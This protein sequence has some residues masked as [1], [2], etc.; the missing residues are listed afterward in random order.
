[1]TYMQVNPAMVWLRASKFLLLALILIQLLATQLAAQRSKSPWQTLSGDAP[2]IIARGGFSGLLPDSSLDAYSFVSMTSV[3]DAVLW[4]D[5]QL[6]K[7]GVGICFPDVKMM[8]ASNIQVAYPDRKNSYLLNGVPTQDWFT[9]DFTFKDL[10]TVFLMRGI[11]SRS[12]AFDNNQY[13]ISTVQNIATRLKPAGFWLNVQHDAFYAQHNLSMSSFL[14]T[15][16]KTVFIDYLSSPEVNFFRNIGGRFGK[17]GPKFVFRFLEKDDIEVSTNQTYGSL[18]GNLTFIKTFASGVLVPKSYIWPLESKYLRPHTSFVQDAHKAGLEVYAS[19]FANDFDLAYN[20]SFDPLAEYL[21][22][23]DNG[24]FSVDGV[25]SDFPLTA[26]SAVDCFSHLGT[27]ASTQVDFLVISK[28]GASG[29]YPGCTDLAYS[30]AIKDGADIID[31][32]LQMSS[33][34]VPFCLSSIDLGESTNAFQSPFRNRSA[35][36]PEL[37]TL[38]KLYSFSLAWSEIQTL[39]PAITNPYNKDYNL[40]RNP[41]ERSSGK[42]VSLSDF[43]N[44]AKNSTSLAG[45]LI[46]VENASYL[47]EK[48]GLDVIKAV[49]DT[50]TESGYGNAKTTTTKKVMIQ[51]TNS[52]VLVD[53]KKQSR[54]ETVYKVEE[55]IRDILDS[56]IED[57]KKFADA[58]VI[59]KT[60]VFPTSESF[61]TGQTNL[62]A[63]LQKVQLPVYVEVFRNEFVS[64]PWD[65][66]SDATVEINSHVSGAGINGTITE[67]PLTA[68]RYKRNRCLTRKDPPTYMIPVLP[69]GLLSIV[70]PT[71]LPPAEAPNP[72]ITEADV[73]EPPLPPVTARSPTTSPGP[74]STDEKSPNGQTRVA[75]SL[76]L[77]AFATVLV[78]LLLL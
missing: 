34:G 18:I 47:R 37:D 4:C 69:A 2:L 72:V 16:S 9:I 48:Q 20:Y 28:N 54:Y 56:A 32:S 19:G 10:K 63:R 67:F 58:V 13:A 55:T 22:F 43:L 59:K 64:Q 31:C 46:S 44:L 53:F 65:F 12:D 77:S 23:M 1:M 51:S 11:L 49:L 17:N 66:F 36:V 14:L 21:S 39:T 52:S 15:V 62:V 42:L 73:T 25:L 27:N 76:L 60:S 7:D 45:V 5:V 35:T 6:T 78:S 24:D 30:K 26:S 68:A 61:T 41:R 57:I 75:L 38:S 70:S 29:D 8:N 40:F 3:P 71:S 74:L 50:L 33:D